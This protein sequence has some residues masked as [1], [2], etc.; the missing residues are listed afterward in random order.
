[1]LLPDEKHAVAVHE[2][3]HALVAALC[4]HADPVAKVSILPAGLSRSG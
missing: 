3:G 1:M 2:A 4:R